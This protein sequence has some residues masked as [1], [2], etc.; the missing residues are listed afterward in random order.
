[1]HG[2]HVELKWIFICLLCRANESNSDTFSL[3]LDLFSAQIEIKQ[4]TVSEHIKKLNEINVVSTPCN[5]HVT[6][7]SPLEESRGEEKR[8]DIY[9]QQVERVYLE[10]Y[11]NK[12][13]KSKGL[14]RL[15][16]EIKSAQDVLD[17]EKAV[18]NYAADVKGFEQKHI[19]WFS[20][21]VTTWRDWID[22]KPT[23]NIKVTIHEY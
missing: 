4:K 7:D 12:R 17:F 20:T 10:Y 16:K 21:F 23:S 15:S 19:K 2:L 8:G 1:M 14:E 18:R 22:F 11:P 9:A 6:P 5:M 13:G 3:N